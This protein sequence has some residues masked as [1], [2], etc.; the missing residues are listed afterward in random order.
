MLRK[1][2]ETEVLFVYVDVSQCTSDEQVDEYLKKIKAE[3][4]DKLSSIDRSGHYD[5]LVVP[6]YVRFQ[7][8]G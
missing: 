6:D 2:R 1:K 4:E 8:A 7:V 3:V 5:I